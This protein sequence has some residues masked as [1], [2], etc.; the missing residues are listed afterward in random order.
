LVAIQSSQL[1]NAIFAP[2]A[3]ALETI[4]NLVKVLACKVDLI[5]CGMTGHW[6]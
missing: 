4:H 6:V 5:G 1:S 3:E 2:S